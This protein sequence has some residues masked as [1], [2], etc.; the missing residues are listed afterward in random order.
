MSCDLT[1]D[2]KRATMI[3]VLVRG[4][5]GSGLDRRSTEGHAITLQIRP[6]AE[7][8]PNSFCHAK[9]M[10]REDRRQVGTANRHRAQL[11]DR[12]QDRALDPVREAP[13]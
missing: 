10:E 8:S 5:T 4:S 3:A 12:G 2:A 13:G 7:A 11:R 1:E 9:A 6:A